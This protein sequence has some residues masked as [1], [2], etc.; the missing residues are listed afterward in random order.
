MGEASISETETKLLKTYNPTEYGVPTKN[1]APPKYAWLGAVGLAS[2]LPSGAITQD[3]ATYIPQT[4]RPL[5]TE[6][7]ELPLP[8]KYYNPYE[9]PNAEGATYDAISAALAIAEAKQIQ[10]AQEEAAD[11]PG[12]I[13]TPAGESGCSGVSA[14][15]AS[16]H[17]TR[18]KCKITTVIGIT[19]TE[20]VYARGYASCS[21]IVPE[22]SQLEVCIYD[23]FVAYEGC[24]TGEAGEHGEPPSLDLDKETN[25]DCYAGEVYRA[26]V[27]FWEPGFAKG[28]VYT[29][30]PEKQ[31]ECGENVA[32]ETAEFFLSFLAPGP[33]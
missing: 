11:P 10:R 21:S 12:T 9:R 27:W 19:K 8:I 13:P 7:I 30:P 25:T 32:E 16:A 20:K 5:Q 17:H 14:C 31:V 33:P 2:E 15:A 28:S 24:K 3:G 6:A 26:W 4:G 23:V 29:T 18:V 1:E 22:Y